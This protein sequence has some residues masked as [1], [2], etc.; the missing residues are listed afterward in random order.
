VS[1]W[2]NKVVWVKGDASNPET[3][4]ETLRKS[5]AVVHTIGTL[6]D[7][8]ITKFSQPGDKGTYEHMNRDTAIAVGSK[9]AEFK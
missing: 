1:A 5:D 2:T 3:F 6:V 8:S 7:T 4:E 9:L